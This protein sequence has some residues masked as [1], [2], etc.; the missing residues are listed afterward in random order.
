MG[1]WQEYGGKKMKSVHYFSLNLLNFLSTMST[2]KSF[3]PI[4]SSI[5]L[6]VTLLAIPAIGSEDGHRA[7]YYKDGEIH[8]NI[9]GQPEGKPLTT[10]HWDFKPSWSKTGDKLV[11]FRRLVNTKEVH[12]WKTANAGSCKQR[13]SSLAACQSKR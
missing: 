9:L 1:I 8:I 5:I 12:N 7:S 2:S 10:G 13:K 6:G 11:F 4:I 3:Q